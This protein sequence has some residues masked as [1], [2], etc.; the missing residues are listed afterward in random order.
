MQV[1]SVAAWKGAIFAGQGEPAIGPR[2]QDRSQECRRQRGGKDP[3]RL[4][5]R[6]GGAVV[7]RGRVAFRRSAIEAAK[8]P[9]GQINREAA[10]MWTLGGMKWACATKLVVTP[11]GGMLAN[12]VQHPLHRNLAAHGSVI[13]Q[14]RL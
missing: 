3:E 10:R 4:C 12:Q 2:N 6:A 8:E 9:P 14:L 7:P 11:G 13:D 1:V 5:A